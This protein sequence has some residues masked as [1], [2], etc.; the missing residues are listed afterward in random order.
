MVLVDST[1]WIDHLRGQVS[2]KT[3][4]L[5]SL[6][7]DGDVVCTWVI[8]QEILQ[9]AADPK[10]LEILRDHFISLPQIPPTIETTSYQSIDRILKIR[11]LMDEFH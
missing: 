11:A 3:G 7:A 1:V 9:G 10:K 8:V 4:K 5:R 6:L 2:E